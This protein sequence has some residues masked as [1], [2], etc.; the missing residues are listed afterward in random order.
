M[1]STLPVQASQEFASIKTE[2]LYK[3]HPI[4][5]QIQ[6]IFHPTAEDYRLVQNYLTYGEHENI[7]ALYDRKTLIKTLRIIGEG[8]D[9]LPEQGM[10]AVNCSE[11]DRENCLIT[12]ASLNANFVRGVKRLVQSVQE[13]DYKGHVLYWL[14]GWPNQEEGSLVLAHVP[15]AFKVAAFKRAQALGF[16]RVLWLDS[17]LVPTQS[18]NVVFDMIEQEG[19]FVCGNTHEIGWYINENTANYFG[20]PLEKTY[21]IPS[22]SAG[23]FGLDLQREVGKTIL[24]QWYLAAHDKYAFFSAR[25]DQNALTLILYQNGIRNY[26]PYSRISESSLWI[27]GDTLFLLDRGYVW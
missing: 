23:I 8:E 9:Q 26:V 18:L 14:G 7:E 2:E 1:A 4:Y 13:S 12:Y 5:S 24:E 21:S 19:H 16:K 25:S 3:T 17:S 15:F 22:C 6:D 10:I 20:V 27:N 11:E